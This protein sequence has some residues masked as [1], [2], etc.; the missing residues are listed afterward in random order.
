MEQRVCT[1]RLCFLYSVFLHY[2][3]SS[4]DFFPVL[5]G[6]HNHTLLSASHSS[7]KKK[8]LEKNS[9]LKNVLAGVSYSQS[10]LPHRRVRKWTLPPTP[11]CVYAV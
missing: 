9:F 6:L 2:Y 8:H 11:L 4:L 3:C 1:G 10:F 5:K 7:W